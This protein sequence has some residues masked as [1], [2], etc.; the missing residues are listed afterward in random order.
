M[1]IRTY[2]SVILCTIALCSCSNKDQTIEFGTDSNQLELGPEG[3]KR[4]IS[5]ASEDSWIATSN[6]PW[7][8]VSPANGRGSVNCQIIID[9]ALTDKPR[10]GIIRIQN[11]KNWNNKEITIDQ[12]GFDYSIE[13]SKQDISVENYAAFGKRYFEVKVNTNVDFDIQ[14]PTSAESWVKYEK[15]EVKFDRGV[16]PR[17]VVV[18]FNWSVNS[19]PNERDAKITFKPK[20]DVTLI[21]QDELSIKQGAAELIPEN[22]RK[23]DSI[24][25]L[26]VARSLGVWGDQ[27]ETSGEK[28]ENW[29]NVQ[30]W[31]E[32]MPG[33]TK[34]KQ[35]RVRY[36]KFFLLS[37]KEG[38]PFEVQYL[39]AAEEL[40]FLTNI[41]TFLLSLETGEYLT[42]LTQLKRL[43]ISAFGLN[44]LHPDFV[45]MKNLESLDLSSNNFQKVPDEINPDNF[46]NLR[47]LQM[48]NNQRKT[49]YDLSNTV[50]TDFGGLYDEGK[51]PT[52]L[53][54]WE[55]DTLR[56]SLNYVHGTIPTFEEAK[57]EK[58]TREE[59]IASDSLPMQLLG[60]AK[61]MP[62]A[63]MFAINL[64]RLTGK[65]P[66]W[67]LYHPMFNYW[68]PMGLIFNQEG[69]TID[70]KKAGF[71]NEP[72]SMD[73][74]YDAYPKKKRPSDKVDE[75][76]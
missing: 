52:R 23:G 26:G 39:T 54:E 22:T 70:D 74:Y 40:V 45:K 25:L 2:L 61:I 11:Q 38:I 72:T 27:W 15:P 62:R 12:K 47:S 73:Y 24:A 41:N 55:L 46:P 30:I 16:R 13:L 14:V 67:L 68:D 60:Q 17:E 5:I 31:E 58:Y 3:G 51:F 6:E 42:K 48:G 37:T 19:Q 7:I 32:G 35:G 1:K 9:S 63:Q 36:A 53:I 49:I 44:K 20:T 10:Q 66:D 21:R 75:T 69:R 33:Y 57:Y 56:L 50:L 34:A 29:N 71:D 59:I 18:R 76:K 64:N 8:T 65:L 43:T 4:N 28:M